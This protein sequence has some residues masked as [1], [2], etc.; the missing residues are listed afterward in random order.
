MPGLPPILGSRNSQPLSLSIRKAA[1]SPNA[2]IRTVSKAALEEGLCFLD[3]R[4]DSS[5]TIEWNFNGPFSPDQKLVEPFHNSWV[6]VD[7]LSFG[8]RDFKSPRDADFNLYCAF[9]DEGLAKKKGEGSYKLC[10][11][12]TMKAKDGR[13]Y[14]VAHR[15]Q[16]NT[17]WY[18]SRGGDSGFSR[19]MIG[20]VYSLPRKL[21]DIANISVQVSRID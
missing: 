4:R 19:P 8:R 2:L 17:P 13:E 10:L 6:R 16:D 11:K 21:E 20:G 14:L 9:T 3:K 15:V 5:N 12:V 18:F 7:Y 1:S